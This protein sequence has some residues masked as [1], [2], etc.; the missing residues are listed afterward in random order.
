VEQFSTLHAL[1]KYNL[2]N[3][4]YSPCWYIISLTKLTTTIICLRNRNELYQEKE[5]L[6]WTDYID[7][8]IF[9]PK[10]LQALE[11][12]E[13]ATAKHGE[14]GRREAPKGQHARKGIV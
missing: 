5:S 1:C 2:G 6:M 13:K 10:L 4:S 7:Y 3:I 11:T 9:R 8:E 14:I 12:V